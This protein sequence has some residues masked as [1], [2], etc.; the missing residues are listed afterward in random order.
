MGVNLNGITNCQNLFSCDNR[1]PEEFAAVKP[2]EE[3]AWAFT[4]KEKSDELD[5]GLQSFGQSCV[6]RTGCRHPA[7]YPFL[8][9]GGEKVAR[10]LGGADSHRCS[11]G[12]SHC[13]LGNAGRAGFECDFYGCG[14]WHFPYSV[15]R[16]EHYM[17]V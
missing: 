14:V 3:H 12:A 6:I 17:G 10:T 9:A 8:Y 13:R 2:N 1:N 15:D 11:G 7:V 16:V 5:T 4:D